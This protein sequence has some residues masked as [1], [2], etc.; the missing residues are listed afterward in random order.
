MIIVSIHY[1]QAVGIWSKT[2]FT[3]SPSSRNNDGFF[4]NPSVGWIANGIGQI[5]RTTN[6]GMSWT[7][8]IDKSNN[9]HWRSIGFFDTLNGF[10]GALG[11]GD[12][13][14]TS[15]K[16]TVILYKTTNA[17]TNWMPEH[18]LSS[19]TIKRGFCGMHILDDSV[20]NA[21][22]RVRG[23]AWFYRTTDRGK[24]WSAKD[25]NEYAGGL[26]DVYFFSKDTGVCV[27]LTNTDHANSS[28]VVLMTTDGGETWEK[29]ITT[30]RTGEWLWKVSFPSRNTGYAS[31][32][33]NSL[34]P[35]YFLKT[36]DGGNTWNE[37]L[38]SNSYYFVQGM[39][40]ISDSVGWLGGNSSN[41]MYQTTDGGDTWKPIG[42]GRRINR[43]RFLSPS[44]GYSIGDSVYIYSL[45]PTGFMAGQESRTLGYELASNYPNPFNPETK[46]SFTL[47]AVGHVSIAIFDS[48]GSL[49][50]TLFNAELPAGNHSFT[51]DGRN[52]AD[53]DVA[54]GLYLYRLQSKDFTQTK[55]MMLLR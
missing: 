42:I 8:V 31:L 27:G 30:T 1:S 26:I 32:Q 13:N 3:P 47:A 14:N 43:F 22:G 38:F 51:W 12:P 25:M 39:G 40:F 19:S 20:I 16:D 48:K 41:P 5:H 53:E 36:T 52:E 29:K 15:S 11:W 7:K 37:K 18:Q 17:G 45:N 34:S 28:G 35:I 10:A 44:T 50:R 49:I 24:T 2:N 21:V 23:P 46:I 55:K 33:R 4:L 9:T 6:G 54:S